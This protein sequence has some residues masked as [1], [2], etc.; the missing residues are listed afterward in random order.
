MPP[1]IS[2]GPS[3]AGEEIKKDGASGGGLLRNPAP[4]E[5]GAKHPIIYRRISTIQG[6]AGFRNHPQYSL[7]S[8]CKYEEVSA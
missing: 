2:P 5:G 1:S 7:Q 6:D 8:T 4:A 3:P